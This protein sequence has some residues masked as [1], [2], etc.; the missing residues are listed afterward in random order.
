MLD[1]I[2]F[3]ERMGGD[4]QLSQA[5]PSELTLA[6]ADTGIST[7]LQSAML[8]RDAQQVEMLLG[9]KAVC[10]LVAPPGPPG[11]GPHHAP[12]PVAPP[13]PLPEEEWEQYQGE[14]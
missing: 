13:P 10:M 11:F 9:T 14:H 2:D 4:A 7:E 3:M 12:F 1:V 5:S 6:L 8:A